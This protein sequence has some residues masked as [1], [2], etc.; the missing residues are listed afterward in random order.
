MNNLCDRVLELLNESEADPIFQKFI[1]DLDESPRCLF[2]DDLGEPI[3]SDNVSEF[4]RREPANVA[5]FFFL[6]AG[7]SLSSIHK[8]IHCASF[9]VEPVIVADRKTKFSHFQIFEKLPSCG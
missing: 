8:I 5:S 4:I 9:H 1:D 2:I 7:F 3:F 6:G